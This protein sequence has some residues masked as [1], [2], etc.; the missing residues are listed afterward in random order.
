M[1]IRPKSKNIFHKINMYTY[2]LIVHIVL[3]IIMATECGC[4]YTYK[5]VNFC[6]LHV[7][8]VLDQVGPSNV[9]GNFTVLP[10][11]LYQL[12]RRGRC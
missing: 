2:T 5:S 6:A 12:L 9:I 8:C 7:T 1:Y 11:A 4:S 10:L 3:Y